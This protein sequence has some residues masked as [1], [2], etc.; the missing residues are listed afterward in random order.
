[1]FKKYKFAINGIIVASV[2][3]FLFGIYQIV[4][5]QWAHSTFENYFVFR[6]C[7]QLL[8]RTND[9]GTC[10]VTGGKII[11]IVKFNNKWYLDGDLPGI[12]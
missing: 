3:I 5:L 12:W 8:E 11:K 10:R 4:Y 9:Y 7:E 2:G 6:G 1:M